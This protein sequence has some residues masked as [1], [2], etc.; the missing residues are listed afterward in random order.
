MR[1][2]MNKPGC[3]LTL[4]EVT[5]GSSAR[6]EYRLRTGIEERH[7]QLKC[8]LD[9]TDFKS[10]SLWLVISQ[11]VFVVL[12]YSLLQ[13]YLRRIGRSQLNRCTVP[14]IRSQ[15]MSTHSVVIL[16]YMNRFAL[17]SLFEYTRMV[18][19]LSEE[20]RNKVLTK[21]QQLE[22]DLARELTLVRTL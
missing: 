1:T 5:D 13:L 10:R 15:L 8:F 4:K 6:D 11:V 12:A 21:T 17:L 19:N 18:L 20:A 22:Q 3:Y 9:L 7:R 14:R 2:G 16:Y